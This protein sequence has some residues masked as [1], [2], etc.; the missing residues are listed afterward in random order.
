MWVLVVILVLAVV[1]AGIWYSYYR[2][3]QRRKALALFAN[4]YGL[5]YSQD[6]PFGIIGYP[7]HLF[8]MGDGRGCEN[9]VYGEWQGIPVQEADFWYYDESTDSQGR[10]SKSYHYYS[11]V[12]A[13]VGIDAPASV[14]ISKESL[15][16]KL[17]DH[18]GLHDIEFE[19]EQ[20]NK[21]FNVKAQDRE[22][23]FKLVDARMMQ[24]LLGT[25]G[26]FEFEV[27]GPWLLVA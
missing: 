16:T 12:V 1:A 4:Q 11:V 15:L 2:K 19:S 7:F 8:S 14:R 23:C 22:F 17:A 21:A 6:D 3:Q 26:G 18:V 10:R 27:A 13:G 24:W 25:G 5:T 20:F 9:L